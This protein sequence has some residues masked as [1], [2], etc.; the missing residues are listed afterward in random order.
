MCQTVSTGGLMSVR[1]AEILLL[2]ALIVRSSSFLFS[3][4]A[5]ETMEPFTLLCLRSLIA[6]LVLAF[7]FRKHLAQITKE[8]V[9]HGALI[10]GAFFIVMVFELYGLRT[11]PASVTVFIE[12]TAIV[13]VPLFSIFLTRRLPGIS[14]VI[15]SAAALIGVAFLTLKNGGG[16]FTAGELLCFGAALTYA[17]AILITDRAAKEDDALALGILPNGFMRLFSIP[18]A[19]FME[20]PALPGSTSTWFCVL[21]LTLFC[22]VIGFHP[23]AGRPEIHG[24]QPRRTLL[25]RLPVVRGIPQ[26]HIL[27]RNDR[28]LRNHWRALHHGQPALQH[29]HK[30]HSR[31]GE[32]KLRHKKGFPYET[33]ESIQSIVI[34]HL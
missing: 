25:C 2:T 9:F 4:I 21:I 1:C 22:F 12:N 18:A 13:F 30:T 20:T 6:F 3:K 29:T 26:H 23:P 31:P 15:S 33:H 8:T 14:T 5:L 28:I 7:I 19:F 17:A 24:R 34:K 10:G 16:S 32:I 27:R 11:T